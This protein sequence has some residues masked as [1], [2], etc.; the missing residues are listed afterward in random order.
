MLAVPG[1]SAP[2]TP[3]DPPPAFL[4][5][6]IARRA[7]IV[8]AAAVALS[9]LALLQ[10]FDTQSGHWRLGV[11]P[12]LDPLVERDHP[13]RQYHDEIQ[14]RFGSEETLLLMRGDDDAYTADALRRLATLADAVQALPGVAGVLG[15]HNAPLA[16]RDE[17]GV[18]LRRLNDDDYE[19]PA[20]S[21][22]LRA[23]VEAH[24]LYRGQLVSDDGRHAA[25]IVTLEDLS[26]RE[27]LELGVA[28]RIQALADAAAADSSRIY[29]TGA[30]LL[31][32]ATSDTVIQQ[33]RW[34]V[35]AITA[36][37]AV[38]LALGFRSVYGV[39]LP[40]LT[41]AIATLWT[42]AVL[43]ALG[44]SLNL[45]TSLVPPLLVTMGLAYCAHTLSEF[46]HLVKDRPLEDGRQRVV[47]LLQHTAGPVMLTGATT[48]VGLLA[49]LINDLPAIRE[50]AWLSALGVFFSA[51]LALTLLPA[52][53]RYVRPRVRVTRR[54]GLFEVASRRLGEFDTRN[55]RAILI[56]A[57]IAFLLSV[58]ASTRIEIGDQFVGVF[59]PDA[60]VR[61]DFEAINVAL[62]G[63]NPVTLVVD[64]DARDGLTQPQNLR[65]LS[66]FEGWLRAQPEVG[67]VTGLVEHLKL[68][69]ATFSGEADALPA[70]AQA[71]QQLMFFGDSRALRGVVNTDRSTSLIQV[72]LKVDDTRD[73]A[74]FLERLQTR[75][76]D[77][78]RQLHVRATGNTVLVTESV[79]RVT[80]GQ[81][82][83]I[84]LALL[85]VFACLSIQFWSLSVG[86]L[87]SMP[88]LLQTSL[89]FGGL[90][91]SGVTLNATTSLVECLVLGLAVDDTI[92]Y[93]ARFNR[94]AR[95]TG[96]ESR[97]AVSALQSVLRPITLTKAILALGFLMLVT[98][99]LHNQ[100]AFG[101][102]AAFTLFAAW[103]VDVFVTPAFMSGVRVVTLWDSL[104][105]NLGA[106]VQ[107]TIPLFAG[108]STRQA[109]IFA[110]MAHLQ[111]VP[112]GTRLIT[113]GETCGNGQ[114]GD[115]AGDIY[116]VIDGTLRI[117]RERDGAEQTLATAGRGAVIGEVG[118]FG[119]KRMAHV[120]TIT[121]VRLLRFDDADQE[122]ICRRYP[123]I[124]ARVFLNLNRLQA[125]RRAG[126]QLAAS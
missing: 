3:A 34:I 89:Y 2:P 6:W 16:Y 31:R 123:K 19:D 56:V 47:R 12:S 22:R 33:L 63:V 10:L 5:A 48:A 73:V 124:A 76:T 37:L 103:L 122:R 8:I 13:D 106:D 93:L 94:A 99:E 86:L 46:E 102:L 67:H 126:Q 9:L 105:I 35:P 38:F 81:L 26:D 115:P 87:A 118:Y 69:N 112:A 65:A 54:A 52:M 79:Q 84:A 45:I 44:K 28:T 15:L 75:T 60:R 116:V 90:G 121:A 40:L 74:A 77:L 32:A 57:L 82:Q 61:Q 72:R 71:A 59:Q 4:H 17:S 64:A 111:T 20:L 107:R 78:P 109:R 66:D 50:F 21:Q 95:D 108:L 43:S 53:L 30:P 42:L 92:H 104:R 125:E 68:L 91:L 11:D 14:R 88:T 62:N 96:S 7:A 29:V 1:S 51:L 117:W 85:L 100:V 39:L 101:W 18:E 119:Q 113:E 25:L 36:L 70:T 110:I 24:P 98:G 83:S 58:A 23:A 49:L 120:D 80:E 55:R 41:I 97:A 27:L 114:A